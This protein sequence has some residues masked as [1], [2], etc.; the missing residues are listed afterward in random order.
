MKQKIHCVRVFTQNIASYLHENL[1]H[2]LHSSLEKI[3]LEKAKV[4][5]KWILLNIFLKFVNKK[6]NGNVLSLHLVEGDQVPTG[7][8]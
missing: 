2:S 1:F 5:I 8:E 4:N 6:T 3:S 7:N